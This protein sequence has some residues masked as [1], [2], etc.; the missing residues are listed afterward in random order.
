MQ[1]IKA[2]F[3]AEVPKDYTGIVEYPDGTKYWHVNGLLHR[4]DGPAIEYPNGRKEWVLNGKR[5]REDGPA[6]EW[7]DGYKEWFLNGK[8][9]RENGPAIEKANGYKAWYLNDELHREDGPACEFAS[10]Y[11]E[12]FLNGELLF[13]LP[14]KSQPF[15]LLEEFLDEEGKEQ[16]KILNQQGIEIWP[17]LPG[18]RELA[19]NWE[20]TEQ[21]K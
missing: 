15:V 3:L 8:R 13:E 9:H 4:E 20:A 6:R 21:C 18:L 14:P 19:E 16:L 1:V 2:K 17:N 5:H 12:W 10:G 7:A 11:K